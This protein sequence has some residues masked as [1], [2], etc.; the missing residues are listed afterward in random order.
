MDSL[1]LTNDVGETSLEVAVQASKAESVQWIIER[2]PVTE[3]RSANAVSRAFSIAISTHDH[4]SLCN[5]KKWPGWYK[6]KLDAG[7]RILSPY[8]FAIYKRNLEAAAVLSEN[9]LVAGRPEHLLNLAK[10]TGDLYIIQSVFRNKMDYLGFETENALLQSHMTDGE[11]VELWSLLGLSVEALCDRAFIHPVLNAERIHLW[12]YILNP[13]TRLA[14]D[15]APATLDA[16]LTFMLSKQANKRRMDICNSVR[17][18]GFLKPIN[19]DLLTRSHTET[20]QEEIRKHLEE[21]GAFNFAAVVDAVCLRDTNALSRTLDDQAVKARLERLRNLTDL[22]GHSLLSFAIPIPE[23]EGIQLLLWKPS[24]ILLTERNPLAALITVRPHPQ[25]G[26][27]L[28]YF[29]LRYNLTYKDVLDP[30]HRY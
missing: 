12:K 24:E 22:R 27:Y 30:L 3:E 6:L 14:V 20:V 13:S 4:T 26:D 1:L 2:M 16:T 21:L 10:K 15:L 28:V 5:L 11:V 19:S 25:W 9:E 7:P 23:K 17:Y 18:K 8:F 29:S